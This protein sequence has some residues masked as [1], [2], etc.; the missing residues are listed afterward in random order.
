GYTL[1]EIESSDIYNK[2][3]SV[4][5]KGAI[6][7][8]ILTSAK[9]YI[10]KYVMQKVLGANPTFS[11]MFA[12]FMANVN[13]LDLL[14]PFKDEQSCIQSFP[15]I[16]DGILIVMF[17]SVV[18]GEIGVDSNSYQLGVKDGLSVIAGNMVGKAIK[19]SNISEKVADMFCK[20]VH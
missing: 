14:K 3:N 19:D 15:Q 16:S 4:D 9:E 12:Q 2:L 6:S 13:P 5:W 7:D 11:R 18:G 8:G 20:S 10:I 17:R 1:Q